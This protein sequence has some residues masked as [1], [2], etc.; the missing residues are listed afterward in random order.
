VKKYKKNTDVVEEKKVDTEQED[1]KL[2]PNSM[3]IVVDR[4]EHGLIGS[5]RIEDEINKPMFVS[6]DLVHFREASKISIG[7]FL[8]YK[9]HDYILFVVLLNLL[10]LISTLQEITSVNIELF[11]RKMLLVEQLVEKEKISILAYR[12]N[13]VKSFIA[14]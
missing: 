4:V 11:T 12:L 2:D 8:L 9:S 10:N 7:D 3:S 14:F 6:D 13:Q 1:E 5:L